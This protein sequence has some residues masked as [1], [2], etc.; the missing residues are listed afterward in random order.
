MFI[1]RHVRYCA[2]LQRSGM[3]TTRPHSITSPG[4]IKGSLANALGQLAS[5][6]LLP[7][8]SLST[9]TVTIIIHKLS[10]SFGN[11]AHLP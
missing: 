4:L 3:K 7:S 8:V 1:A 2:K 11:L 6:N 5:H 10:L 9:S